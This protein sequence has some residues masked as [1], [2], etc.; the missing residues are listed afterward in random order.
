M[1]LK[2]LTYF[3]ERDM[4]TIKKMK[5][6]ITKI[7]KKFSERYHATLTQWDQDLSYFQEF[8]EELKDILKSN[9]A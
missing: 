1:A 6:Q 3:K 5:N 2:D 8:A 7:N 9:P 4:D